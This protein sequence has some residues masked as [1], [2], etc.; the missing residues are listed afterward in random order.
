MKKPLFL[1][2]FFFSLLVPIISSSQAPNLGTASSFAVFTSAG[3]FTNN[4]TTNITGNI[5][6]HV[7]ALTGFPPGIVYGQIHVANATS[8]QAST[9]LATAY[10]A[11]ASQTPDSV[12][13]VTL[14]NNQI[15]KPYIYSTGAASTLNGTLILDGQ[16]NPNAVFIFKI[17]GAFSTNAS[18]NISLINSATL[19]NVYWQVNGAF[20]LG[21][22]SVF[23]GTMLAN[24][25]V[26]LLEGAAL[27]GQVLTKT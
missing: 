21:A 27:Y 5:G 26:S 20:S 3:A 18:S 7:G 6:T 15:L 22:S 16:G 11:L 25:A 9:D 17:D 1:F 23:R 10:S 14:G 13:S 12:I 4:G 8:S 19:C 24:G 2:V